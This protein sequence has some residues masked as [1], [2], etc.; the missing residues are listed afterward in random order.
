MS[1][2]ISVAL[3]RVVEVVIIL[4]AFNITIGMLLTSE[5]LTSWDF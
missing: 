5:M 4:N 3:S 1:M 2:D